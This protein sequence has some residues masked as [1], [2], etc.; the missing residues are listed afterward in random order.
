M[1]KSVLPAKAALGI[2]KSSGFRPQSG[3]PPTS[4]ATPSSENLPKQLIANNIEI[5]EKPKEDSH[6]LQGMLSEVRKTENQNIGSESLKQSNA[7][8]VSEINVLIK[9]HESCFEKQRELVSQF[10]TENEMQAEDISK[11]RS[12]ISRFKETIAKSE[13]EIVCFKEKNQELSKL[14]TTQDENILGLRREI[15][16]LQRKI[17]NCHEQVSHSQIDEIKL[18]REISNLKGEREELK[19]VLLKEKAE[20]Q[21]FWQQ[22]Q[23]ETNRYQGLTDTSTKFKD[24]SRTYV[25]LIER[26]RS[27]IQSLKSSNEQA[28]KFILNK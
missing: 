2:T 5:E 13:N 1:N 7:N 18:K 15:L 20:K 21:T 27:E 25:Q 26:M 23:E 16:L 8:N 9:D 19:A 10:K 24:E 12:E 28:L 6:Q 14:N 22:L 17:E 11:L 3:K 4:L